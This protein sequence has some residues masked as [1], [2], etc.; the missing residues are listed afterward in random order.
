V[1]T[2]SGINTPPASRFELMRRGLS[3]GACL[4]PHGRFSS[5]LALAELEGAFDHLRGTRE[6]AS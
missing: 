4:G 5:H 1:T 2:R 6:A 3:D